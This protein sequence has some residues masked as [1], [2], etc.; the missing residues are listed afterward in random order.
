M[1]E[2]MMMAE[3][4]DIEKVSGSRMATPLAPPRPG[5]TPISTPRTMP[6]IIKA[7]FWKVR[8]IWKPCRS[9]IT[10]SYI[11]RPLHPSG[12]VAE[13]PLERADRQLDQEPFLE[14]QEECQRH[15]GADA[16]ALQEMIFAN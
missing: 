3:V 4:G 2:S 1:Q 5:S 16:E 11:D 15:R 12:S 6:S 13:S 10:E 9:A 8:A 7:R 14:D